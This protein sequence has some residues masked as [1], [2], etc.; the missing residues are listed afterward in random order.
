M[1]L[2]FFYVEGNGVFTA[3]G[4]SL[5]LISSSVFT[6]LSASFVFHSHFQKNLCHLGG[7]IVFIFSLNSVDM[8]I[9]IHCFYHGHK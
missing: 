6:P 1:G 7:S 8:A 3:L 4:M 5:D 9:T 2:S